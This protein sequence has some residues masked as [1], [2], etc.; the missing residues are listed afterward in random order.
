MAL[1]LRAVAALRL[2]C[3]PR[4]IAAVA[5]IVHGE[6]TDV[7]KRPFSAFP[8]MYPIKERPPLTPTPGITRN[9]NKRRQEIKSENSGLGLAQQIKPAKIR[10]R[11][12]AGQLS[13]WDGKSPLAMNWLKCSKLKC[14]ENLKASK[15]FS[16]GPVETT[17]ALEIFNQ[18]SHQILTTEN[19][20]QLDDAGPLKEPSI[21]VFITMSK[22]TEIKCCFWKNSGDKQMH[23]LMRN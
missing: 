12:T 21:S 15:Y 22:A 14:I 6:N 2:P 19:E 23:F 18:W 3:T 17:E 11:Q 8:K 13:T 4:L 9:N 7:K 20:R 1:N 16:L 5:F 10:S